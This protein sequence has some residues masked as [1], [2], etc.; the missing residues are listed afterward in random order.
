MKTTHNLKPKCITD[1]TKD[2]TIYIRIEEQKGHPVTFLCQFIEYRGNKIFGTMLKSKTNESLYSNRIK[3][4][5]VIGA[6]LNNCSLYGENPIT[7]HT[8]FHWFMASGYAIYPK[9]YNNE[10]RDADIISEH[11][12]FGMASITRTTSSSGVV[13]FGS[14]IQHKETL[15]LRISKADVKR[16]LSREWYHAMDEITEVEMR[17]TQFT[18]FITSPTTSGVPCTIKHIN[19][20]SI[21]EPPYENKKDMFSKEFK[22]QMKNISSDMVANIGILEKILLKKSIGKADKEEIANLFKGIVRPLNDSIPFIQT[23]FVEQMDNTVKE[24]KGEVESF[25]TRRLTEEGRKAML[26]EN[27]ETPLIIDNN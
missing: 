21:P 10:S 6:R 16:N 25:I 3:D 17:A 8:S 24:A 1:F 18:D 11:P 13:L 22:N 19:R 12:S 2:D 14:S 5:E 4:K 27:G 15:R 7:K 9:D 20:N 26:G 23:S